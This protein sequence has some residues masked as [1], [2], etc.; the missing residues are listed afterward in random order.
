MSRI[1]LFATI[2]AAILWSC[3]DEMTQLSSPSEQKASSHKVSLS[4]ALRRAE[5]ILTHMPTKGAT[6]S[7]SS[8]HIESVQYYA[9]GYKTRGD[10]ADT[11]FYVINYADNEG[12]SVL[13]ADDRILPVYAM[14]EEGHIELA[15]TVYNLGL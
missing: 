4:D 8:R 2:L 7:L 13:G 11:L 15:D 9:P 14:S 6:R 3:T 1:A 12:F 5:T 10:L